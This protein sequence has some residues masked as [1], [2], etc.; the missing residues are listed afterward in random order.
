MAITLSDGTTTVTLPDDILWVDRHSWTPVEQTVA[1]SITGASIVDVATRVNG[2]P[3]TLQSDE[4]H[5]WMPYSDISQLKVWG[6]E[7]GKELVLTIGATVFDVIFRHQEKPAIDVYP[8][9][10]Y[11]AP[12][13]QDWFYGTLKFTEV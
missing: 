11:N 7:A 4:E 6:A 8:I 12:D 3:I 2:R 10:D 5:A 1:T 13:S 9:I